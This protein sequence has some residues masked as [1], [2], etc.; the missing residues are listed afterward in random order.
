MKKILIL[1]MVVLLQACANLGHQYEPINSPIDEGVVYFYRP[2]RF[3]GCGRSFDIKEGDKVITTMYN[4]GYYPHQTTE[5]EHTYT[6]ESIENKDSVTLNVKKGHSY[7]VSSMVNWG[8]IVGRPYLNIVSDKERA[9][10]E[11]KDCKIII[12]E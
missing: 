8:A 1:S 11:I 12:K 5:G 10:S 4:N 6:V 3:V 7:Y 2:S 9:V